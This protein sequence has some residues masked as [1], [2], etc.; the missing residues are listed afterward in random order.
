MRA[1][2]WRELPRLEVSLEPVAVLLHQPAAPVLLARHPAAA[3]LR[4]VVKGAAHVVR[5]VR[6]QLARRPP[7]LGDGGALGERAFAMPQ[8]R[9]PL[10]V[11]LAAAH[12]ALPAAPCAHRGG[13]GASAT[14][15][16]NAP[17]ALRVSPR[18]RAA[19]S[20]P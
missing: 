2:L 11:V 17:A 18:V 8:P 12:H 19:L 15:V 14:A 5:L 1:P 10:A 13:V 16:G 9:E 3:V 4:A 7:A 6:L 20:L